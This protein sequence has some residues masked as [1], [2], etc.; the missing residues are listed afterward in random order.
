MGGVIDLD[1]AGAGAGGVDVAFGVDGGAAGVVQAGDV[2]CFFA[3][4]HRGR[5]GGGGREE[6]RKAGGQGEEGAAAVR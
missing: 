2:E 1:F 5:L 3:R 4:V 6:E